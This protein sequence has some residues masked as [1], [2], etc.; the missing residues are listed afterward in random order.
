[1]GRR[2]AEAISDHADRQHLLCRQPNSTG[3]PAGIRAFG[4]E[5]LLANDVTLGGEV[6]R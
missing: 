6:C 2:M 4:S 1:M 3:A 5:Q